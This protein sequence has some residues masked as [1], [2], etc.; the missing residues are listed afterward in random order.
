MFNLIPKRN[1]VIYKIHLFQGGKKRFRNLKAGKQPWG[2]IV[3]QKSFRFV[4]AILGIDWIYFSIY[5]EH[6]MHPVALI[7][8]VENDSISQSRDLPVR[9]ALKTCL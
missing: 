5:T 4:F 9:A 2:Y 8:N 7:G 6:E 3:E 1:H